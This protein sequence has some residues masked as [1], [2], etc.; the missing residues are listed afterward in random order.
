M[1]LCPS[2]SIAGTAD[3]GTWDIGGAV[4]LCPDGALGIDSRRGKPSGGADGA[5]ATGIAGTEERDMSPREGETL[6]A[7]AHGKQALNER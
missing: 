7:K 1:P 5:R 6:H 3:A 4:R 2:S